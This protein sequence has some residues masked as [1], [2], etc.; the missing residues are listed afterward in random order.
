MLNNNTT[1]LKIKF[2]D[3]GIDPYEKT[4][5]ALSELTVSEQEEFLKIFVRLKKKTQ[6]SKRAIDEVLN[7]PGISLSK[8]LREKLEDL[9]KVNLY[10]RKNEL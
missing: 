6:Y 8:Q 1:D 4:V 7:T 9:F 10:S 2:V 3:Q 5:I